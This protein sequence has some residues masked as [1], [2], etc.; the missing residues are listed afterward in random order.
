MA[1]DPY[2]ISDLMNSLADARVALND[3]LSNLPRNDKTNRQRVTDTI[4][5]IDDA[6]LRI[7]IHLAAEG[8]GMAKGSSRPSVPKRP[9]LPSTPGPPRPPSSVPTKTPKK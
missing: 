4:R 9:S 7:L 6:R 3:C 8:E 2:M 5:E 1:K